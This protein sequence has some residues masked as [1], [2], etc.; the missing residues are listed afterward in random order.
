[1]DRVIDS[2]VRG[3]DVRQNKK[4]NTKREMKR[5]RER[6]SCMTKIIYIYIHKYRNRAVYIRILKTVYIYYIYS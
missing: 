2:K 6:E 1:L 3:R 5:E 4:N